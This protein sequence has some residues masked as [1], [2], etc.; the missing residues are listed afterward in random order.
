MFSND[1]L[2]RIDVE[3]E[4]TINCEKIH[5]KVWESKNS[6]ILL[7]ITSSFKI[8][9]WDLRSLCEWV[10]ECDDKFEGIDVNCRDAMWVEWWMMKLLECSLFC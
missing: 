10:Y 6:R 2:I 3:S 5:F 1:N 9:V 7:R 4:S 8:N